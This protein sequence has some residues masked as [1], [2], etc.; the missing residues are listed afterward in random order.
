M[1]FFGLKNTS[2]SSKG[3]AW[4]YLMLA[5][6]AE[7]A[8]TA[9]MKYSAGFTRLIPS[10]L[11][12]VF[13]TISFLFFAFSIKKLELGFAYATWSGLGTFLI[14]LVGIWMFHEPATLIKSI[15]LF[16]IIIGVIGLKEI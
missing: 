2:V 11:I 13:Y 15:S 8:G 9:A 1:H 16:C 14:S 7:V 6:F 10:G 3:F 12:F 5:I 4:L